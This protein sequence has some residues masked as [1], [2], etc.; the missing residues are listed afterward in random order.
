MFHVLLLFARMFI[1]T[2][3]YKN[4]QVE[5]VNQKQELDLRLVRQ[6]P[7]KRRKGKNVLVRSAAADSG[8][9]HWAADG[10]VYD[11]EFE[12]KDDDLVG[13]LQH[14]IVSFIMTANIPAGFSNTSSE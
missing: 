5:R 2:S 4:K 8:T 12:D 6:G 14:K 3:N 11:S 7:A 9:D 1:E 10:P 13:Y